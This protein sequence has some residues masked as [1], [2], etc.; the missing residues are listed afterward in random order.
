MTLRK[1]LVIVDGR[2]SQLPDGD[3]LEIPAIGIPQI[4]CNR[5]LVALLT[6]R[7][8]GIADRQCH[9]FNAGNLAIFLNIFPDTFSAGDEVELYTRLVATGSITLTAEPGVTLAGSKTLGS[10]KGAFLKFYSPNDCELIGGN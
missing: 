10:G 7:A 8:L 5:P 1:P 2:S 3:T 9:L 6:S 4:N